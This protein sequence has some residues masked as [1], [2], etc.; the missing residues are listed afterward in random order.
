M[1]GGLSDVAQL[2][3][4]LAAIPSPS[5]REREVA[6]RVTDYLRALALSVDEDDAG[7]KIDSTM[8][9]ILCRVEP[10]V[11]RNSINDICYFISVAVTPNLRHRGERKEV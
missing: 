10:T 4:E 6:D 8:G 2:F 9:N 1:E 3:V 5:G 11:P 7:S